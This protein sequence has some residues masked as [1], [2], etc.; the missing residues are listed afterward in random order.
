MFTVMGA[1]E[2]GL[3]GELK[4]R[5]GRWPKGSRRGNETEEAVSKVRAGK[6]EVRG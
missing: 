5:M 2:R 1:T 6:N 3:G 4:S